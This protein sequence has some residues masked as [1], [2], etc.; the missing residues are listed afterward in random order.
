MFTVIVASTGAG[1]VGENVTGIEYGGLYGALG[2]ACVTPGAG[3]G[4][5]GLR[6]T[7]FPTVP[8][9]LNAL[10][11]GGAETVTHTSSPVIVTV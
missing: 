8:C 6:S 2:R 10:P 7:P 1:D 11:V 9:Q 4:G 5:G 3:G